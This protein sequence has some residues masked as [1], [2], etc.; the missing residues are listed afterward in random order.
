MDRVI[1]PLFVK[2]NFFVAISYIKCLI[3]IIPGNFLTCC[4]LFAVYN[5]GLNTRLAFIIVVFDIFMFLI[6]NFY[7]WL[8]YF[9]KCI[10]IF[11]PGV[12]G[13]IN[14]NKFMKICRIYFYLMSFMISVLEILF[15][16]DF[17]YDFYYL[18][19]TN[20]RFVLNS[21]ANINSSFSLSYMVSS[22]I[23]VIATSKYFF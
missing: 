1:Y 10:S 8:Y 14:E 12:I 11:Y 18:F 21:E 19:L 4:A 9:I 2:C 13:D 7:I 17:G 5:K 23:T 22:T 16:K 3:Q 6:L 20:G 15:N